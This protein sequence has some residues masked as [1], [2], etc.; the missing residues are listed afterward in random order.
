[1]TPSIPKNIL[2]VEDDPTLVDTIRRN[3][4]VRGYAVESAATGQ[5]ARAAVASRCPDLLLLDIDLPDESGWE[6]LRGIRAG[7]CSDVPTI[8][9]SALRP[10]AHLARNLRCAAEL[11]K[12][13]P[14][15]SLLRL[16]QSALTNSALDTA[17]RT[18]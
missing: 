16:V 8:V 2:I 17:P 11:E 13:F 6:L 7:P 18:N 3:L 10:N 4:V 1:M 9:I 14:I 5:A 15:E 12:P